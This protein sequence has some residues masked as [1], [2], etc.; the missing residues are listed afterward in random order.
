MPQGGRRAKSKNMK[1]GL[2]AGRKK[3]VGQTKLKGNRFG[4]AKRQRT[5]F[6]WLERHK[7]QKGKDVLPWPKS[8]TR[9]KIPA[10]LI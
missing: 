1:K 8:P 10:V 4:S 6:P 3:R 5:S 2:P 9:R 7:P